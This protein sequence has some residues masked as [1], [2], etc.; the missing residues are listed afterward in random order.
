[1]AEPTGTPIL[2]V[3]NLTT[4]LTRHGTSFNAVDR[5]SFT[6][7]AGETMGLVGESGSGKSMCALSVVGLV[8]AGIGQVTGGS[9]RLE[10]TELRD[11]PRHQLNGIRGKR[12]G[13]IF[14]D[15]MSSLNPTLTVGFQVAEPLR[16][17]EGLGRAQSLE[18]ACD[19]L[20]KVGIPRPRQRLGD[21]PHQF[22]GGM[23]Q[24]VMIA[25]ALALSPQLVIADEPTTA[26]DVTVQA[27]ILELI[28]SL[29]DEL[30]SAVLLITHDLGVA[31]GV[32]DRVSVMYAGQLV[33]QAHVDNLFGR[34]KM[35]YT[36]GLLDC[37]PRIDDP[38]GAP[39]TPI[40][41]QSPDPSRLSTGC[42]FAARCSH[43]RE[44]CRQSEPALTERGP[45]W[46]ARC[47]ATDNPGG[48]L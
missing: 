29:A 37:L 16:I 46:L 8:P 33:E 2:K 32:C 45:E 3:E 1:M 40:P 44:V 6:I 31:A 30:G 11:L 42:R 15:P 38:I 25:M 9:V 7:G 24:R 4:T 34:P 12:I 23:R 13:F 27:Q 47:H 41:G 26:L 35:P 14:Q 19:M 18:R 22:S 48:W 5:V 10:G 21:Y 20:A 17:H 28:R 39:F 36:R 43:V